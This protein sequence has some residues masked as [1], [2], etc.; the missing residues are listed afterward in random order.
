MS[1]ENDRISKNFKAFT[2]NAIEICG[3]MEVQLQKFLTS[4]LGAR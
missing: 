1:N 2:V 4:I 3:R